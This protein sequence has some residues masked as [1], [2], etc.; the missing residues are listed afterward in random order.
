MEKVRKFT[1]IELLVVIAIIGIIASLLLP[2]LNTARGRAHAANCLSNLRQIGMAEANYINDFADYIAP[3]A[4][5]QPN[6]AAYFWIS[7]Y[8][9]RY[10][11]NRK[12]VS[13]PAEKTVGG[14][15]VVEVFP[16]SGGFYGIGAAEKV[17]D[18]YGRNIRLS[19]NFQAGISKHIPI[20]ITRLKRLSQTM[21]ALDWNVISPNSGYTTR[22][23]NFKDVSWRHF[24][25]ANALYLDGRAAPITR[26]WLNGNDYGTG[27]P[28][29]RTFWYGYSTG[30]IFPL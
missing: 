22:V 7:H 24:D 15:Q 4:I 1:L 18:N 23:I 29:G 2:A 27:Q 28:D 25:N 3:A 13:C 30:P 21:S 16:A 14:V 26:V 6:G 8:H 11:K 17:N 20:S 19:H 5:S 12:V 9:D 10:L